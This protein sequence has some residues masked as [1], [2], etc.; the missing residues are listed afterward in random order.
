[1]GNPSEIAKAN[2]HLHRSVEEYRRRTR[3][4]DLLSYDPE[5]SKLPYVHVLDVTHMTHT[6]PLASEGETE[7]HDVEQVPNLYDHWNHLPY[8]N[9][10]DMARAEV[11]RNSSAMKAKQQVA[12]PGS[13][14]ENNVPL[15]PF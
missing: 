7:N 6:H 5:K 9:L 11:A 3:Q 2:G 1:M 8:T 14:Y 12:P 15:F 13:P 10:R 4:A